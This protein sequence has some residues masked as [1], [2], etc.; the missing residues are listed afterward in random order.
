[1]PHRRC[2]CGLQFLPGRARLSA[3]RVAPFNRPALT[4]REQDYLAEVLA[5]RKFSGDGPFSTRCQEWLCGAF[6]VAGAFQTTSGTHALE[7]AALLCDLEPGDEVIL[8]SFAYPTTA[9][10]FVRCGARLVFVDIDP[11][12]MNLDPAEVES[13]I[14]PKTRV[15]VALHYG[16]VP[17]D[18]DALG[19]LAQ[20]SSAVIVEDAAQAIFSSYRGRLCGTLGRFGC[21][22]FHETKNIHCGEGGALLTTQ[23]GDVG[24]AEIIWEKGTDR[25]R[26]HRG[27]IDKY[28][29]CDIGSSYVLSE[30]NSAFLLAQLEHGRAITTDRL[31]T[32][33][34]YHEQLRPLAER[35]LIQIQS[36]PEECQHNGHLFWIK[37]GDEEERDAL[38]RWMAKQSITS[39]FHYVPLHSTSAGRRWGRFNGV[40]RYT[41]REANR[42]LRLPLFYGF[43]G[44]SQ[45][46][47]SIS[48]FYEAAEARAA[49]PTRARS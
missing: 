46:A 17:C 40:D 6:D 4:G 11:A 20:R 22:S 45:V 43:T 28:S 38:I 7:M 33:S 5:G 29:W 31:R 25:S 12:T 49:K 14:T 26:F 42:L 15:I 18:M 39:V 44:A 9:S 34:Q 16:G 3:V 30:L 32:W 2:R 48:D 24:R 1:M 36:I 27:E 47:A 19:D 8:P 37:A 23:P 35:K 10:A 21:F 41:T 13:A